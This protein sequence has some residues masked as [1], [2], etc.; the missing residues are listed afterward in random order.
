MS[1]VD[2]EK[3]TIMVVEDDEDVREAI[4]D[5]LRDH[6]FEVLC[7]ENGV[8]ALALLRR[9]SGVRAILLDV[10][11]PVM[12]GA[13]FRGEQ[14]ADPALCDIPLV[15]LTGRQDSAPIASMLGATA[16]LQKPLSDDAL[17]HVCE[18]FR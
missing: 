7:S 8:D 16:C 5:L 1:R 2:S 4:S 15:L 18:Q 17:L 12:N 3:P 10:M 13:T 11:M 9:S 6:G 14:L